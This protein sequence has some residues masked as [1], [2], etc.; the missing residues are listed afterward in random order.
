MTN[1]FMMIFDGLQTRKKV[2]TE[3]KKNVRQMWDSNH[4]P[5]DVSSTVW[6]P[7]SIGG[8][9]RA[10]QNFALYLMRHSCYESGLMPIYI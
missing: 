1:M 6:V 8:A 4:R 7:F 5:W 9:N 3:F 2:K 10:T